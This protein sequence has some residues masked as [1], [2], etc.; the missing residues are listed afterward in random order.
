MVKKVQEGHSWT[1][2]KNKLFKNVP[3][4]SKLTDCCKGNL[5]LDTFKIPLYKNAK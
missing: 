1:Q 5:D 4:N 2:D 3:T